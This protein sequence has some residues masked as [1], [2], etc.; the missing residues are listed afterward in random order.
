MA[1]VFSAAVSAQ[2]QHYNFSKLYSALIN[3]Q[4]VSLALDFAYISMY[5]Q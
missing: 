5:F 2:K 1:V 4:P 3:S